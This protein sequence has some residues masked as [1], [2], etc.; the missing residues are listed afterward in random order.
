MARKVLTFRGV[1]DDQNVVLEAIAEA[2]RI[3]IE[4]NASAT[5]WI[6]G[7]PAPA[8]ATQATTY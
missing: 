8:S 1:T 3:L 4:Y 2:Q 6:N 5:L 7:P